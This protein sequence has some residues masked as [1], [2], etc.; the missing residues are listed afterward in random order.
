MF[1]PVCLFLRRWNAISA[2]FSEREPA[3]ETQWAVR[4]R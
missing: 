4:A 3:A 2:D 1:L